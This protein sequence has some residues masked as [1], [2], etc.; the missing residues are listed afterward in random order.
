MVPEYE[1]FHELYLTETLL[2][3]TVPLTLEQPASATSTMVTA[4]AGA[5]RGVM[6][7]ALAGDPETA[8]RL[9]SSVTTAPR[10]AANDWCLIK[11]MMPP[12]IS[13]YLSPK[14]RR[15]H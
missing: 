5:L 13:E 8:A 14:H 6:T 1:L 3:P 4:P 12:D 9:I 11:F 15:E 10:Q 7:E 2:D